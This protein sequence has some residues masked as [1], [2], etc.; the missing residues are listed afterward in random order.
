LA[1]VI[2]TS[3]STGRPKGVLVTH[4]NVTSLLEATQVHFAFT[5]NDVWTFFHSYAFDFSVWEIWGALAYGGKLVIVPYWIS[6]SAEAFHRL[7]VSEQVTVLNQTPSAFRQLMAADE[8]A[9]DEVALKLRLVIFGGETL[10]LQSL[11][12]WFARH[13]DQKPRLVNMFGITETTVHVT[14][15]ALTAADLELAASSVIGRALECLQIYVVDG[16]GQPVPIGVSG[17]ICVGGTGLARGY[18]NRAELTAERFVPNPFATRAGARLYKSGDRARFLPN[19]DIEYL[20]RIDQQVKVR[21]FRIELGE[22]ESVLSSHPEIT[23]S[24]VLVQQDKQGEKRLVAYLVCE[25]KPATSALRS[26]LREKLPEYMVPQAFVSLPALPL[27]SNGKVDRQVLQAMKFEVEHG[28]YVPPR[29]EVERII[30]D[31]WQDV[32]GVQRIGIHDNFFDLGGQSI[33]LL[34]VQRKMQDAFQHEIS[35]IDLFK[36]PTINLLAERLKREPDAV[37]ELPSFQRS[38]DRAATRRELVSRQREVRKRTVAA[39]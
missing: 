27:T 12:L 32:L 8:A 35:L 22:I 37:V 16:R 29:N 17:E 21:G 36:Y 23:V 30:T 7:L 6:R 24:I 26:Y 13:G 2:Y 3:G 4:E 11:R 28:Q 5:E 20:G 14:Y 1:Y 39:E 19:G 9:G 18:L 31:I 25:N 33:L 38:F 34:K 10:E 15:R